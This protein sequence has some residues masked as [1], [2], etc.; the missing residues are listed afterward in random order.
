[1]SSK[2]R[3]P[4]SNLRI[5]G[6]EEV[7]TEGHQFHEMNSEGLLE[8]TEDELTHEDQSLLNLVRR[9]ILTPKVAE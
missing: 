1:M 9:T 4:A 3:K 6:N 2:C 5:T 8:F 7:N